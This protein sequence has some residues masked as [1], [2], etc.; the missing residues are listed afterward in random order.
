MDI[1]I[2]QERNGVCVTEVVVHTLKEGQEQTLCTKAGINGTTLNFTVLALT[3]AE[4]GSC[5][6]LHCENGGTCVTKLGAASCYCLPGYTGMTCE[7]G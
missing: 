3:P 2:T 7:T 1:F 4:F 6:K 5:Q